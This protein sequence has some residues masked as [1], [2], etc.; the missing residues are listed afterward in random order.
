[1]ER[2]QAYDV[3]Q[4]PQTHQARHEHGNEGVPTPPPP[5]A[6]R[7][8]STAPP[9]NYR[10]EAAQAAPVAADE[11]RDGRRLA[12]AILV[13]LTLT[14][15]T[16]AVIFGPGQKWLDGGTAAAFSTASNDHA[17]AP[18]ACGATAPA[19]A[20]PQLYDEAPGNVLKPGVD[21]RATIYT[22]CGDF[23]V[24]LLEKTAPHAVNNFV[25]LAQQGFYNGLTWH[26]VTP[27]FIIQTG[28]PNAKNGAPPDDAGYTIPDDA[29]PSHK[30]AYSYGTLAMANRGEA[31]SGGSQF[32]VVVH[33]LQSALKGSPNALQI[34]PRYPVFG[35][36]GKKFFGSLENIA[37][38]ST[39]GGNDA[40]TASS[41]VN[42]I[43]VEMVQITA[44]K[45][46]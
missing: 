8:A 7:P 43:Y 31:G 28:D 12:R 36:V 26:Q 40:A 35:R 21:Y 10:H 5:P 29:L 16:F 6:P 44:K 17:A 23:K 33:D 24:D 19:P 39:V 30:D 25:F 1:M 32:F 42:P 3:F 9:R 41:P 18:A 14:T 34:E 13:V 46:H 11:Q 4:V 2:F 27:N 45:T 15:A 20:S 37:Q 22:S 38:Q